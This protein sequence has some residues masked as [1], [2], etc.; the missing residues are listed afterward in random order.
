MSSDA[1]DPAD[2]LFAFADALAEQPEPAAPARP[3]LRLLVLGAA[4]LTLALP[5]GDVREVLRVPPITRVPG[6]AANVAGV[7]NL[8]GRVLPV[9]GLARAL[10]LRE[11]TLGPRSRILVIDHPGGALGLLCDSVSDLVRVPEDALVEPPAELRPPGGGVRAAVRHGD[12]WL[13]ALDALALAG[14]GRQ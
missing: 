12:R 3:L 6:A 10:G 7:I 4:G 1:R 14:A 13:L 9:L 11:H 5:V 8:R 2:Q